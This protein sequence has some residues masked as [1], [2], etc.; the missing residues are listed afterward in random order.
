MTW[1]ITPKTMDDGER[2]EVNRAEGKKGFP[3][4]KGRMDDEVECY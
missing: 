1:V 4:G 3:K 2:F